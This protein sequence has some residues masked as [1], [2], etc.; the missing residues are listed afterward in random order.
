MDDVDDV[1]ETAYWRCR[2]GDEFTEPVWLDGWDG[3]SLWGAEMGRFFLQLW[4][5]ET[6]YDGKP[7]LW[8]TGADPNPLLDVGSVALAV[9][10]A[11]GA[12]PL[13]ACQALCILPPP[14]VGDLHAAAAAQLA[15]AQRAGSDPY[16]AGQVFAC[17]WVLGRGTVS[18]GSGWAWPGGAPTYRHIGAELHINTGH[19][20]QYPDDPARPYRA[21]IDEA[22]FRILKAGAN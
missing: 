10:A 18:P 16:S 22:L 3:Q 2:A 20:Y 6:R 21:G 15:S 1:N 17:H 8:I 7:D 11:T 12:D 14:P 19:M 9:V 5:N 4:R 13:R